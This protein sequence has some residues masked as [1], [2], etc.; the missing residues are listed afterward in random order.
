MSPNC[1]RKIIS[2]KYMRQNQLKTY[3]KRQ[4]N[5][6]KI[7]QNQYFTRHKKYGIMLLYGEVLEKEVSRECSK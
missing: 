2:V 7:R 1:K 6:F 3:K 4:E 5:S